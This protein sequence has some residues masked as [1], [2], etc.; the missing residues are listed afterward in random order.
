MNVLFIFVCFSL[1]LKEIK[2]SGNNKRIC[3]QSRDCQWMC[4][5]FSLARNPTQALYLLLAPSNFWRQRELCRGYTRNNKFKGMRKSHR[6]ES[7]VLIEGLSVKIEYA[8]NSNNNERNGNKAHQ[9]FS[10]IFHACHFCFSHCRLLFFKYP[11]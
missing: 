8:N 3:C 7:L 4:G 9:Q 5:C 1:C 2:K 10:R 11:N 6:F